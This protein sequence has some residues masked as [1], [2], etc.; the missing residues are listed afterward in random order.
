MHGVHTVGAPSSS[1]FFGSSRLEP[2][3]A[4]SLNAQTRISRL[5]FGAEGMASHGQIEEQLDAI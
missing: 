4:D 1:L 5:V 3:R 2:T